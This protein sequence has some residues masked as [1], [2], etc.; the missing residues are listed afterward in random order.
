MTFFSCQVD[1]HKKAL[2]LASLC[3]TLVHNQANMG[4]EEQLTLFTHTPRLAPV[5]FFELMVTYSNRSNG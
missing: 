2:K 3:I 4:V 5:D 1:D